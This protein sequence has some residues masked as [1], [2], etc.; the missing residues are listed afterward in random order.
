MQASWETQFIVQSPIS[1]TTVLGKVVTTPSMASRGQLPVLFVEELDMS[2]VEL[3]YRGGRYSLYLLVPS[4]FDGLHR[5]EARLDSQVLTRA[6]M[7]MCALVVGLCMSLSAS[8][9][10]W[11]GE[12]ANKII[13]YY[14][15][16]VCIFV[17]FHEG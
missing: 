5:L 6:M 3:S 17:V 4:T 15:F 8:R 12:I 1:F 11:Y 2:L 7:M 9:C 14:T 16:S 13:D 10:L